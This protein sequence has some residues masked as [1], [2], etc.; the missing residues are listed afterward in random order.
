[1][2]KEKQ[3]IK[4]AAETLIKLFEKYPEKNESSVKSITIYYGSNYSPLKN[5]ITVENLEK[6]FEFKTK[7]K[8]LC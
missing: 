7:K 3:K 1:M 5:I 8:E 6:S 2:E 4:E